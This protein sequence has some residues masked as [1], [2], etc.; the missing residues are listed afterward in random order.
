MHQKFF[1]E[2]HQ[3]ELTTYNGSQGIVKTDSTFDPKMQSNG[4]KKWLKACG[5]HIEV[6]FDPRDWKLGT[7]T[8]PTI[9]SSG[10]LQGYPLNS[11]PNL[12]FATCLKNN[13]IKIKITRIVHILY[14]KLSIIY[15]GNSSRDA[16][17]FFSQVCRFSD[18][19]SMFVRA[20]CISMVNI[21]TWLI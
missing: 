9:D 3:I 15:H 4:F 7:G 20:K 1:S 8:E 21:Y 6:T 17:D 13:Y 5:E 12:T 11:L 19:N 18:Q 10:S 14:C 16:Y 2:Q